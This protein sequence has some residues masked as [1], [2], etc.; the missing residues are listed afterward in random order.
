MRVLVAHG[1]RERVVALIVGDRRVRAEA[2]QHL[3]ELLAPF[4]RRHH[5]RR[6]AVGRAGV[7]VGA[8]LDQELRDLLVAGEHRV[9]QRRPLQAAAVELRA[10][11][12]QPARGLEM[13][14]PGGEQERLLAV[15]RGPVHVRAAAHEQLHHL[16]VAF[17][18]RDHQP[19]A[20]AVGE[21]VGGQ[22]LRRAR[23][24]RSARRRARSRSRTGRGRAA[25]RARPGTHAPKTSAA[26][27]AAPRWRIVAKTF[28]ESGSDS[29]P[30]MV[31]ESR[32]A[33]KVPGPA[34]CVLPRGCPA[35]GGT[36]RGSG[37]CGS[38]AAPPSRARP[39]RRSARP[40]PRPPARGR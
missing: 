37:P 38:P 5:Q 14:A 13:P 16:E 1:P 36:R 20:D 35:R 9:V 27:A 24:A 6:G 28:I 23:R 19:G 25:R 10:A 2:E 11:G 32:R 22:A 8:A 34:A 21:V 30:Y 31:R 17:P 18:R 40:R 29:M 3:R 33:V 26:S 12:E 39:S 7:E 15:H 4:A